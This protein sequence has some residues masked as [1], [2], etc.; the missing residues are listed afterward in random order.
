MAIN[1]GHV[2]E[3]FIKKSKVINVWNRRGI[4]TIATRHTKET[5][6]IQKQDRYLEFHNHAQ[7]ASSWASNLSNLFF[8]RRYS[9]HLAE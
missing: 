3:S 9:S 8:R 1:G 2:K 4:V 6:S 7:K 5:L